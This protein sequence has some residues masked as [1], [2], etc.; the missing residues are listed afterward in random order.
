MRGFTTPVYIL[1][2][3]HVFRRLVTDYNNTIYEGIALKQEGTS[4]FL[5]HLP[6]LPYVRPTCIRIYSPAQSKLVYT[7]QPCTYH[8]LL[9]QIKYPLYNK[10]K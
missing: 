9:W 6:I 8:W 4:V 5:N 3:C 2:T 10:D 7:H 1:D